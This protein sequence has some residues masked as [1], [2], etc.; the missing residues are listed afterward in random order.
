MYLSTE[1]M[2]R[3]KEEKR[4]CSIK[5]ALYIVTNLEQTFAWGLGQC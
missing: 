2:S 5:N 3:N 4:F 1:I